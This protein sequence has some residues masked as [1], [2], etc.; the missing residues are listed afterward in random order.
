MLVLP[1]IL[2]KLLI[3]IIAV[4]L[5]LHANYEPHNTGLAQLLKILF[6]S[7]RLTFFFFTINSKDLLLLVFLL[8]LLPVPTDSTPP[9]H[10]FLHYSTCC[11]FVY[12]CCRN[13]L[14]AFVCGSM[15]VCRPSA[16]CVTLRFML[17]QPTSMIHN[18]DKTTVR[19]KGFVLQQI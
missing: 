6:F 13:I 3:N 11:V 9:L 16:A 2:C 5:I 18:S 15:Q 19:W 1:F 4:I 8:I 12:L 17:S 14:R 7:R 10:L